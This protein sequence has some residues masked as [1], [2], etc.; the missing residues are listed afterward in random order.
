MR[1]WL[2]AI[3]LYI[4][5][6]LFKKHIMIFQV[7]ILKYWYYKLMYLFLDYFS[8]SFFFAIFLCFRYCIKLN[9]FFFS[10]CF[11]FFVV[12]CVWFFRGGVSCFCYLMKWKTV[13]C[14]IL[15]YL[16]HQF[17]SCSYNFFNPHII[18]FFQLNKKHVKR[19]FFVLVIKLSIL[20]CMSV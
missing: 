16:I 14:L 12:N 8:C 4:F 18:Q 13:L 10:F 20:N 11:R 19:C 1:Y 17:L 7:T 2:I 15:F 9:S 6:Y 5:L 3:Y